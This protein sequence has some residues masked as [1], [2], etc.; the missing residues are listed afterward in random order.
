MFYLVTKLLLTFLF[1]FTLFYFL[2]FSFLHFKEDSLKI[3]SF[4]QMS[5]PKE[6][7][8]Q[9]LTIFI[10]SVFTFKNSFIAS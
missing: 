6:S 9:V 7:I 3:S 2:N 5:N 8:L 10:L 1:V 4:F